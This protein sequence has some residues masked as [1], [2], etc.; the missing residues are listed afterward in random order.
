VTVP[1]DDLYCKQPI[2]EAITEEGIDFIPVCKPDSHK[3]LYEWLKG[4]DGIRT[5]VIRRRT[6]KRNEI[7]TYRF[8]NQIPLCD[9]E[10]ASEVNRC[11]ITATP[12]DD[13]VICR[14]SSVTD[15]GITDENVIGIVTAGRARR[16]VGNENNN[17]LKT[18]GYNPEH[19]S[20]HGKKYLS[21]LLLTLNLPAFL[22]H[23]VPDISDSKYKML[24]KKLPS[25]K[26]FSDDIR[27][28]TRYICS[29]SWES[30]LNF[31]IC[32]LEIEISN[33]G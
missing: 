10:K 25:R 14:N 21:L 13:R 12:E 32:G 20:G 17:V 6:G 8:I 31:M 29:D 19:N 23:T 26:T 1:G 15:H 9:A 7:D 3:T 4:A 16:K 2:C 28:L 18:E 30:L 11:E 5:S 22:F 27:A 33:S 24:R